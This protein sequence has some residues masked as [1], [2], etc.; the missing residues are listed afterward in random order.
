MW[1]RPNYR[2]HNLLVLTHE[3]AAL[4]HVVVFTRVGAAERYLCAV[5]CS[6]LERNRLRVMEGLAFQGLESLLSLKL[7]RNA[8]S[9]L[10]DGTFWGLA[11]ILS[12]SVS[13]RGYDIFVLTC[14]TLTSA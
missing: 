3:V 6:E 7:K 5:D 10:M 8:I 4:V 9:Q 2:P 13:P 1:R 14:C 11:K 12:L